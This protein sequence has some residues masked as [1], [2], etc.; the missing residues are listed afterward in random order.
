MPER[1]GR[2]HL[3]LEMRGRLIIQRVETMARELKNDSVWAKAP[4]PARQHRSYLFK[5][6]EHALVSASLGRFAP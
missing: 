3:Q 4:R 5:I 2:R 6:D 1:V